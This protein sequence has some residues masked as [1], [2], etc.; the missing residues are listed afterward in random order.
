MEK[1]Y[2]PWY[3]LW[4]IKIRKSEFIYIDINKYAVSL[5]NFIPKINQAITNNIDRIGENTRE[6]IETNFE[7][8]IDSFFERLERYLGEY[9][10][11]MH[12]SIK[13]QKLSE[14]EQKQ[15]VDNLQNLT[16]EA[17]KQ[18]QKLN[19]NIVRTKSLLN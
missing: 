10:D 6:Y 17:N 4:L 19:T 8:E 13:T 11:F 1:T 5:K 12:G 15:I 3:F 14:E 7:Q 18:T 9:Q 2:R 16:K